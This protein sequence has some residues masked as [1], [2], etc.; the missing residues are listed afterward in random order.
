MATTVH[1]VRREDFDVYIGR[2]NG[3]Y[4]LRASKW[5]NPFVV[6]KD[7]TR[8]E[9]IEKYRSALL[10]SPDLLER[11]PRLRGLRLGCWCVP[12]ACHGT[13][14]AELADATL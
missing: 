2:A 14:L 12:M 6:G 5:A 1:H 10:A 11:G 13:V 4:G 7:G 9:V 8:E 3:R